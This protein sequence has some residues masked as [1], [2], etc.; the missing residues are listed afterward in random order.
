LFTYKDGVL[1]WKNKRKGARKCR[2]AGAIKDGYIRVSVDQKLLYAHRIIFLMHHGYL[3]EYIDHVNRN[4]S[5][6][7]IENLRECTLNQ[8]SRNTTVRAGETGFKGVS[9]A[10]KNRFRAYINVDKKQ[11]FLGIYDTVEQAKEARVKAANK[12]FGEFANEWI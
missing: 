5:D 11:K 10:P 7:R 1:Y 9:S 6:N 2:L 4:K 12:Y 3:P 8:N